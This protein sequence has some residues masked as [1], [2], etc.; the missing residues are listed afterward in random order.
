ME[1]D[2]GMKGMN[3]QCG[4]ISLRFKSGPAI[5]TL[6]T[7]LKFSD[8]HNTGKLEITKIKKQR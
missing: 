1:W 4:S 5:V 2:D 7:F 8:S 6:G 3:S